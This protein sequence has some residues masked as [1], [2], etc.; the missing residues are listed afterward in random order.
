MLYNIE[1]LVDE[2]INRIHKLNIGKNGEIIKI[3]L[4]SSR[5]N[6][7]HN[8]KIEL[9]RKRIEKMNYRNIKKDSKN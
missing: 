6:K 7:I 5:I 9:E 1:K 2:I 3:A 4:I 8:E